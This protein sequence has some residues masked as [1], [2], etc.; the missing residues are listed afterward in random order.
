ML[1]FILIYH[2]SDLALSE[3]NACQKFLD[4]EKHKMQK[5]L[6]CDEVEKQLEHYTTKNQMTKSE[7]QYPLAVC[8]WIKLFLHQTC[9]ITC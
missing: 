1:C 3:E 4:L 2:P 5:A 7:L 8:A 9:K 6:D